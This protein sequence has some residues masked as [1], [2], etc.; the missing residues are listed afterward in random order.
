MLA[1]TAQFS[2]YWRF[3]LGFQRLPAR[4][5]QFEG[6]TGPTYSLALFTLTSVWR[7][8]ARRSG[9]TRSLRTQQCV[10]SY[11]LALRSVPPR[12]RRSEEHT[13]ELQ[14]RGQLVCRLLLEKKKKRRTNDRTS[15]K[16]YAA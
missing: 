7:T 5:R 9:F 1:S 15:F 10:M 14:S 4:R 2:S 6:P 16:S 13:S 12:P 8:R 3:P 11:R